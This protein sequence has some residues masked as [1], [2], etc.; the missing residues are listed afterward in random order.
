MKTL[1]IFLLTTAVVFG[2]GAALILTFTTWQVEDPG[3]DPA[4]IA[5]ATI[6]SQGNPDYAVATFE[7]G[8][9]ASFEAHGGQYDADTSF[10]VGSLSKTL[11]ATVAA[12][13]IDRGELDLDKPV[14][15]YLP[16]FRLA[17]GGDQITVRHLLQQT[18]GLPTSAGII[19]LTRP[20]TT[21]EQRVRELSKVEP[22]T[23]P[24]ETFHYS[25][26]N[27]AVLGLIIEEVTGNSYAT[28]LEDEVLRP[29]DMR[30]TTTD[31]EDAHGRDVSSGELA[32]FGGSV[33]ADTEHFPGALPD[34]Y[35]ISTARDLA[36][37][38]DAFATGS[39]DGQ[40]FLSDRILQEIRTPPGDVAEDPYYGTTYGLGWRVESFGD[41]KAYWHEGELDNAHA[42]LGVL[43]ESRTGLIVLSAHNGQMFSGDAPFDNGMRALAGERTDGRPDDG[44]YRSYALTITAV[45]AVVIATMVVDIRRWP[46]IGGANRRRRLLR[47]AL[48]R[49]L[50]AAAVW[51]ATFFGLG[52]MQGLSGPL[53]V[54][55]AWAG[56]PDLTVIMIGIVGYLVVSA[57]AISIIG[58][59]RSVARPAAAR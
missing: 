32:L 21:L 7:H 12:R 6:Q 50:A 39:H 41:Q 24:G 58:G 26:K 57:V 13:L 52:L 2:A 3:D 33:P 56:A 45:A 15:D 43:P 55:V 29:L 34:G 1:I 23:A 25:N 40:R 19:D 59:R 5:A 49:L 42:N 54:S 51:I 27:Y 14:V 48:P 35:L 11:T 10:R 53:P 9:I 4:E 47:S 38:A 36:T 28:A 46:R 22:Q 37:F 31:P 30:G 18:S 17:S 44:G 16:W 20:E 8:E